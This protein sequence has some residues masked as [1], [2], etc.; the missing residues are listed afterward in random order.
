MIVCGDFQA[1]F[2]NEPAFHLISIQANFALYEQ[3]DSR[4][5]VAGRN[6][7]AKKVLC[8]IHSA[9]YAEW[10]GNHEPQQFCS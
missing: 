1:G 2:S 7:Q 9:F 4:R 8:P 6:E 5:R 3:P 10:V